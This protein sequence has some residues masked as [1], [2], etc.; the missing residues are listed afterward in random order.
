M[1]K[2]NHLEQLIAERDNFYAGQSFFYI[3]V[4]IFFFPLFIFLFISI[5]KEF[6]ECIFLFFILALSLTYIV[7]I[8]I[9]NIFIRFNREKGIYIFNISMLKEKITLIKEKNKNS[10]K[11]KLQNDCILDVEKL[12]GEIKKKI[13]MEHN[14]KKG[15]L[16]NL[17]FIKILFG[18]DGSILVS[19]F[20]EYFKS[21]FSP[22]NKDLNLI[23]K[24]FYEHLMYFIAINFLFILIIVSFYYIFYEIFFKQ[25]YIY[26]LYELEETID[27]ILNKDSKKFIVE[28]ISINKD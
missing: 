5:E 3:L 1:K 24:I 4:Y 15:I 18:I 6:K 16:E 7:F 17:T 25:N 13:Y 11:E 21:I 23:K 9:A 26:K 10:F 28:V 14:R 12:K 19:F 20:S 2:I 22:Y 27:E 8:I